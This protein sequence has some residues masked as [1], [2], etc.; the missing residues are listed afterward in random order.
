ML[1]QSRCPAEANATSAEPSSPGPAAAEG[2]AADGAGMRATAAGEAA[3]EA[4]RRPRRRDRQVCKPGAARNRAVFRPNC[5]GMTS[6]SGN[7]AA[8]LAVICHCLQLRFLQ[9][10]LR[11]HIGYVP[12]HRAVQGGRLA[13]S[14]LRQHVSSGPYNVCCCTCCCSK[15]SF[16]VCFAKLF[17]SSVRAALSTAAG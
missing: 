10:L 17:T 12:A 11:P 7:P 6:P 8:I 5:D 15:S 1:R 14:Q 13:V 9:C 3:A 2:A 4:A 16:Y